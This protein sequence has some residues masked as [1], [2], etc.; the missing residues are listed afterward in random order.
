MSEN[1]MKKFITTGAVLLATS[2]SSAQ[3]APPIP[4]NQ[5]T[6]S[7]QVWLARAMVAEAG[8]TS[9]NDHI[10]IAYVLARRWRRLT[11]RWPELRFLD[12]IRNYCA[13]LGSYRRELTPRQRWLRSLSWNDL[14]PEGW[15]EGISWDR[16][17]RY[18]RSILERSDRWSKGNL[19]D[20]C[21]GR[22]WHWGGTIDTPRGRMVP[23]NCGETQNTF[24]NL[25]IETEERVAPAP[26]RAKR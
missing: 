8:W 7:T 13:G 10:A 23:V 21:R 22:A 20:P 26:G 25:S 17:L 3:H 19:L 18:W 6:P 9:E 15:P 5:W 12:V 1:I 2:A 4:E 16:H 24:Y 11:E 14:V